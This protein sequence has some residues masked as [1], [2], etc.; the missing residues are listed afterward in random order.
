[1]NKNPTQACPPKLQNLDGKTCR[2]KKISKRKADLFI[3]QDKT[4]TSF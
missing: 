1:M 3:Q 2:K 4:K